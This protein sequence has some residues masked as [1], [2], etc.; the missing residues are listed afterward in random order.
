MRNIRV[1]FNNG[2]LVSSDG[3]QQ[4][5]LS[6]GKEYVIIGDDDAFLEEE[7]HNPLNPILN[8]EDKERRILKTYSNFQVKRILKAKQELFFRVGLGNRSEEDKNQEYYFQVRLLEDLY[9]RSKDGK[10]WKLCECRCESS[11]LLE[12]YLP[13]VHT[14]QGNSLNNLF[15]NVVT[16]YFSGKRSTACNAFNA[17][18]LLQENAKG[19]SRKTGAYLRTMRHDVKKQYDMS[20]S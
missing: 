5:H 12:G 4:I 11:E 2:Q 10:S 19:I 3:K 1:V 13:F 17:F 15:E 9:L 6:P 18:G 20:N 7:Y 8:E 16:H 14:I